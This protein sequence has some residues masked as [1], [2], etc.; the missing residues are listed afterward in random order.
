MQ[1]L[2]TWVL[3][4]KKVVAAAWLALMVAGAA[5]SASLNGAFSKDFTASGP[6]VKVNQ[7][8]IHHFGTGGSVM[9]LVPVVTV[10]RGTTVYQPAVRRQLDR[11]VDTIAAAVPGA[12]VASYASTGN[13]VFVSADGRT[14]FAL[15]YPPLGAGD[16][17]NPAA[18]AAAKHAVAHV[19][20][21]GA[22]VHLTGEQ[23]LVNNGIRS[24]GLGVVAETALGAGGALIVLAFVFASF[25]ALVPLLTALV[26]IMSTLLIVRGL[27]VVTSM[28]QII[29]LLIALIGL[30]VAIDYA[31]LIITR[32]REERQGGAE[33]EEAIHKAMQT[34]GHAVMFSGVTVA[35]GLLALVVL[36]VPFLRA[37]GIGGMLIPLVSV[38]VAVT[39]LPVILASV[40]P[41]LD[42]PRIRREDRA[43]RAWMRWG[44]FVSK[45][46][47][48]AAAAGL[49]VLGALLVAANGIQL[50]VSK[51]DSLAKQ[52]D[53]RAGL[54]ELE[55][56]GI[57]AGAIAPIETLTSRSNAASA[58]RR[59]DGVDGVRGT[60]SPVSWSRG[61]TAIVDVVTTPDYASAA[62]RATLSA[63]R[64]VAPTVSDSVGGAAAANADFIHSVY[65]S[66][67]L[68]IALIALLTFVLLARAFRSL[69]LPLKA[70][71]LNVLSVAAA[72]GAIV[73]VWQDGYGSH[74]LWGL[75]A[76]ESISAWLPLMM[77]AFLYGLS[78]DYEVFILARM[79]EEYDATGSTSEA[80]VRGIAR[81]GRLVTSAALILFLGFVSMST[82][83][84]TDVKVLA[85]GLGVGILLDATIVRALL[86]PALVGLFG[87]WNW[88][89]PRRAAVLLRVS[90][91]PVRR[92]APAES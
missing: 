42:W 55:H 24:K 54:V 60:V 70:V 16:P 72:W 52:G 17:N 30:G 83:S 41:R 75:P 78:M 31:L 66:F 23:A 4:H 64:R 76:T 45:H 35:V 89:L 9:P 18:L 81:T 71:A 67:P 34:A 19:T 80:S 27:A 6:A 61:G 11:A 43:S 91:T 62:G 87:R 8:I 58:A 1:V 79:R 28:S 77:F 2:T 13:R 48:A 56:S 90:P 44:R 39:L 33:N 68:M 46:R 36:P 84:V 14:T 40:G 7:S 15:V 32:W 3:R 63:V 26:A 21:A 20:V 92:L 51:A 53:A 38:A 29:E 57:G 85:T 10:P 69:L 50:G 12:R 47:V 74:L 73:L 25:I 65:G 5:A 59:L 82:A 88:W 49:A 37:V 22:P 86:V